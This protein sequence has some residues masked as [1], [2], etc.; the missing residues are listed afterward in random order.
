LPNLE[1]IAFNEVEH[2]F[3]LRKKKNAVLVHGRQVA[4][5]LTTGRAKPAL[6]QQLFKRAEF[7]RMLCR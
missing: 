5:G 6:L 4:L 7:G 2:F 1:Q 3:G